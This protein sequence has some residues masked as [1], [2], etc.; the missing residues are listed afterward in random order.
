MRSLSPDPKQADSWVRLFMAP[1]MAHCSGGEGP[2]TFDSLSAL[3][4][5]VEQGQ[6]PQGHTY[7]RTVYKNATGETLIEQWSVHEAG[8]AWSGGSPRGSY[9]DSKGPDASAELVRFFREHPRRVP[10]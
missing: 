8:H 3:E 5:W 9:A 10:G 2:D 1:G 4:H 6:A 7:T